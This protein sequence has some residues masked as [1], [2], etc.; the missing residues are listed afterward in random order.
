MLAIR[1]LTSKSLGLHAKSCLT[2][3]NTTFL[4]GAAS[5]AQSQFQ[6]P[7]FFSTDAA[8]TKTETETGK[9]KFYQVSRAFGFIISD[10]DQSEIFVHRTNIQGAPED[11]N[12]NP[13]LKQNERVQ[14]IRTVKED[15]ESKFVAN[16][17]TFEDGSQIPKYRDDY[18]QKASKSIK[19]RLGASIYDI[20]T[21]GGDE[22]ELARKIGE[23][24][25]TARDSIGELESK[26]ENS[27]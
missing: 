19:N 18:L 13:I 21:E 8:N 14:Y 16:E 20:L 7:S 6:F 27:N 10:V 2:K 15:D 4:K 9:V 22:E 25:T 26:I 11:D 12:M 24:Y 5:A 1:S 3:N 23:A 17:V